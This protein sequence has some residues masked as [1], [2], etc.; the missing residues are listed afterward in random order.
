MIYADAERAEDDG[1]YQQHQRE[2]DGKKIGFIFL[3]II[4]AENGGGDQEEQE[5]RIDVECFGEKVQ[6]G[7]QLVGK[8][9]AAT[10]AGAED[11]KDAAA[12]GDVH[13]CQNQNATARG[14]RREL[15]CFFVAASEN[16][17][18]D[19]RRDAENR[20][21]FCGECQRKKERGQNY[22]DTARLRTNAE[23]DTPEIEGGCEAVAFR[24]QQRLLRG[25]N[26]KD[27]ADRGNAQQ[28]TDIQAPQ[29]YVDSDEREKHSR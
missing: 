11:G 5:Y 17:R 19:D 10:C 14:G 13:R 26:G 15:R 27:G 16:P 23:N 6:R 20:G 2:V 24:A 8:R 7:L 25:G 29:Q 1:G 18:Q 3:K 9:A 4:K 12:A 22:T 28:Q 21:E